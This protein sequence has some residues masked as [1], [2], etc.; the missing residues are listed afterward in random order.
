MS[1]RIRALLMTALLLPGLGQ[2]YLGRTAWGIALIVLTNLLLLLALVVLLKGVAPA[3]AARLASGTV[4]P[5]DIM[6]GLDN[7]AGYGRALLGAF[8]LVWG[9]AVADILVR[10]DREER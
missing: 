8:A 4:T 5:A 9:V 7:V 6:S 3:I 10:G 2:L 1:R